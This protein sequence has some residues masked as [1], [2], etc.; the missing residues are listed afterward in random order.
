[1]RK[2]DPSGCQSL[3]RG[4]NILRRLAIEGSAGMRL[5]D[6]QRATGL[7]RPTVHR[8]LGALSRQ[9]LVEQRFESRRYR[10]GQETNFINSDYGQWTE[11]L[12]RLCKDSLTAAAAELGDTVILLAR[13][14]NGTVC[15]DRASGA[16]AEQPLTVEVG[17]RRPLGAGAGG[18]A[19]LSAF[20]DAQAS[21]ILQ[22]LKPQFE[23]FPNASQRTLT[24]AI[25]AA[26]TQGYAFSD[27]YVRSNVRG[28]AVPIVNRDGTPIG[29]LASAAVYDRLKPEDLPRVAGI[30]GHHRATIERLLSRSDGGLMDQPSLSS[31][32]LEMT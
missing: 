28:V 22:V 9:G 7:T 24:I 8:I 1:M 30:L 20:D 25:R 4:I 31:P 21:K 6:I 23:N 11:R 32:E 16:N 14:G 18:L 2:R 13:S 5:I 19:I 29:A 26:R 17:T 10:V 3:D 15:V 12:R 27:G